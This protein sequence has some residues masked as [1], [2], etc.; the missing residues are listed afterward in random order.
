ML[1]MKRLVLSQSDGLTVGRV[2]LVALWQTFIMNL[3]MRLVFITPT[4]PASGSAVLIV[5][6][7]LVPVMTGV[8]AYV[9]YPRIRGWNRVA[10]AVC[11]ALSLA[12]WGKATS[13]IVNTCGHKIPLLYRDGTM[14]LYVVPYQLVLLSLVGSIAAWPAYR[15]IKGRVVMQDGTL[16]PKCGYSLVGNVSRICPECG[17]EYT[18]QELGTTPEQLLGPGSQ[19]PVVYAR[20]P[21]ARPLAPPCEN[22]NRAPG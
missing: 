22:E 4:V 2:C 20:L 6:V 14:M 19:C 7:A 1:F 21:L 9:T 13:I 3:L 18:Y 10:H 16:C 5:M 11:C 17:R 15:W 8:G 12:V